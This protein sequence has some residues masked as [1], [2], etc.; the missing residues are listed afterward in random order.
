MLSIYFFEIISV[1]V[2]YPIIFLWI[3]A[4]PADATAANPNGIKTFLVNGGSTFFIKDKKAFNNG[5]KNQA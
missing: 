2:P 4:S 1:V 5:P 3:L